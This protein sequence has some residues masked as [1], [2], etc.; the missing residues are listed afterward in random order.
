MSCVEM[1]R[2]VLGGGLV[3]CRGFC[4]DEGRRR[5]RNRGGEGRR[6]GHI[7]NIIDGIN[8][9][10]IPSITLSAILSV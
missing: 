6:P 2:D 9:G 10:M 7:L 3:V 4:L 5:R 8:D 1:R